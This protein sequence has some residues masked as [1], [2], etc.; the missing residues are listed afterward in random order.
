VWLPILYQNGKNPT[1]TDEMMSLRTLPRKRT[2]VSEMVGFGARRLMELEVESLTGAA[3]GE[4]SPDRIDHRNGYRDRDRETS[5][6]TVEPRMPKLRKGS[7]FRR[8]DTRDGREG[9]RCG[10]PRGRVQGM[11]TRAVAELIK[12]RA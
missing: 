1:I 12:A 10:G 9:T 3:H 6:G 4:R 8:L 5:A 11:S 2:D 7:Y